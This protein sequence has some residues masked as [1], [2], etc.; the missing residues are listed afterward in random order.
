MYGQDSFVGGAYSFY[1][2][3][4]VS[5]QGTVIMLAKYGKEPEIMK[6]Q[7]EKMLI[8]EVIFFLSSQCSSS[9]PPQYTFVLSPNSTLPH[10]YYFSIR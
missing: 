9:F 5:L 6:C 10:I 2:L 1:K 7:Q 3:I 8:K 4:K